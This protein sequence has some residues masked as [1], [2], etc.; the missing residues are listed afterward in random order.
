[1]SQFAER[2][3][4]P[5]LIIV[6]GG[7]NAQ[8]PPINPI[9]AGGVYVDPAG[10]VRTREVQAVGAKRAGHGKR[11][12]ASII[13]VP[14][15]AL[16]AEARQQIDENGQLTDR[17]RFVHGLVEIQ[18]VRLDREK[19]ELWIVGRSDVFNVPPTGIP[20]GQ[21]TGRPVF[22]IEDIVVALRTAGPGRPMRPFGCSID[23]PPDALPRAQEAANRLVA[24]QNYNPREIVRAMEEAIGQQDVR[25]FGS[26][27]NTPFSFACVE[28]D[29]RLKRLSLGLDPSP[30]KKVKSHLSLSKEKAAV[31][32]RWWFVP[33][34]GPI[35]VSPEGDQFALSG[36]R[37]KV[38][39]SD[40]PTQVSTPSASARKF[41][42][43]MNA[44]MDELCSAIPEFGRLRNLADIA[45]VSALI[46]SDRLHE[47]VDW[48]ASWV[49]N[50]FP[51]PE[52][53]VPEHAEPLVNMMKK[54]SAVQ[55]AVGG[56]QIDVTGVV[57]AENRKKERGDP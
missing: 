51:V 6:V 42:E 1:M 8:L 10:V 49:M 46:S 2:M 20:I 21:E 7:A 16:F 36:P 22:L 32:S 19:K 40:S 52:V 29:V 37:L 27:A 38:L 57:E 9:P 28:A 33:D 43:L 3:A 35:L 4:V 50:E 14:L 41:A 55:V 34:Y 18:S 54:G 26:T 45:V 23:L 44:N 53:P 56:V 5:L 13:E 12:D 47:K 31:Y 24:K 15:V 11:H 17:V 30:V 25:I 39:A 48:D